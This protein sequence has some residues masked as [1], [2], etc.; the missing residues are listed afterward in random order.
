MVWSTLIL[1]FLSCKNFIRK[2][3]ELQ[4]RSPIIVQS[5]IISEKIIAIGIGINKLKRYDCTPS[6]IPLNYL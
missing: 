4:T 2:A 6:R 5:L 1:R 3:M